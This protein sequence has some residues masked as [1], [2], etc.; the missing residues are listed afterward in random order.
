M[1]KQSKVLAWVLFGV[2]AS[3][4]LMNAGF[5][6]AA[7][8]S[9]T[10]QFNCQNEG[11]WG[12][13]QWKFYTVVINWKSTLEFNCTYSGTLDVD[14]RLYTNESGKI[15][16]DITREGLEKF[17]PDDNSQARGTNNQEEVR[18]E[19]KVYTQGRRVYVLL[20]VY[21]GTGSSA[22]SIQSNIPLEPYQPAIGGFQG[23][24][25][26]NLLMVGGAF[27][28]ALTGLLILMIRQRKKYREYI[29]KK[30]EEVAKEKLGT[31][32]TK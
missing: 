19:N 21:S 5:A 20:F 16:W 28:I 7:V 1:N 9:E 31:S 24:V 4:C 3:M 22:I 17:T 18:Y 14:A 23:W 10:I 12:D 32:K 27:A 15:G 25:M 13:S 2:C 26:D 30:K 8:T 11:V 6:R 29:E